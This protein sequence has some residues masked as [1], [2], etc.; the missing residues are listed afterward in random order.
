MRQVA[1]TLDPKPRLAISFSGGRTSAVMTKMLL[2]HHR[3]DYSQIIVT[4]A[5]TGAEDL[6]TLDF[7]HRCDQEFGW[8]VNWVEAVV[9]P[10]HGKGTRH[11]VVT[12]ETASRNGEPFRDYIAKYGIPNHTSPKC[13]GELK[14]RAMTDFLKAKG[15]R[16]GKQKDHF[17]AIGIRA[18]EMDRVSPRHKEE[19]FIYP[20]VDAGITKRD[21]ALEI[22]KWP[23][24]LGIRGDHFGNCTWCWKKS[25]RKLLTVMSEEPS[26]FDFPEA[27]ERQFG[28]YKADLKAGH[29][30]RRY[31]FRDHRSVDD[32]RK[33]AASG[34]RPYT[35]DP[36]QHA[37]D[38]DP[39]MDTGSACGESC[40]IGA[41][42][43]G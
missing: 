1:R 8:G 14:E 17:T 41:D 10:D 25:L 15:Y 7:V 13:T 30:G 29:K 26:A 12:Y 42:D 35:D 32:L 31:F 16:F 27:M 39:E 23:F 40:E 34:F 5:N 38:F 21:V 2:D 24:D 19:K 3:E 18:D 22:K 33:L 4:F 43:N 28:T 37:H 9:N 6:A 11:R 36:H 20:L